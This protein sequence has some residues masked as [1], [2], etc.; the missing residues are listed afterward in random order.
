MS[1]FGKKKE[2]AEPAA[3]CRGAGD[4]PGP[5]ESRAADACCGKP[6]DGIC[7]VKVL[8]TGCRSC[9]QLYENVRAAVTKAGIP[10]EVE[11]VTDMEKIMSY[12]IMTTPALVINGQVVSAGKVLKEAEVCGFLERA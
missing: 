4:F 12:G 7:C 3:R 2:N 5:A 8:G 1:L 11:Y 6:A 9:H 10:V